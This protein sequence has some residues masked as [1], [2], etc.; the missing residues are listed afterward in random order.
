MWDID[1]VSLTTAQMIG[2]YNYKVYVQRPLATTDWVYSVQVGSTMGPSP[3][4]YDPVW[5]INASGKLYCK[6]RI[7]V[8]GEYASYTNSIV[9]T[10]YFS[11]EVDFVSGQWGTSIGT[12]TIKLHPDG[13]IVLGAYGQGLYGV[14][15]GGTA[16]VIAD[17]NFEKLS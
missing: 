4:S 12:L 6:G 11:H 8:G 5:Y 1:T 14:D 10:T 16:R 13:Q 9:G 15:Y 3:T 2:G 17:F 7:I